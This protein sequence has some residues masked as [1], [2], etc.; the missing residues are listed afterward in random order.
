MEERFR[1]ETEKMRSAFR[2]K[3][4]DLTYDLKSLRYVLIVKDFMKLFQKRASDQDKFRKCLKLF[5]RICH[6]CEKKTSLAKVEQVEKRFSGILN[7]TSTK[8]RL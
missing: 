4:K 3:I 1:I 5:T 6:T 2:E 8:S 7:L